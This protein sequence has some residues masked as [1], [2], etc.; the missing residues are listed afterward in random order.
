[1]SDDSR[2]TFKQEVIKTDDVAINWYII[3]GYAG[4]RYNLDEEED[5]Q[6]LA[7]LLNRLDENQR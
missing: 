1:M 5:V 2:F 7:N 3:D 4:A 6:R